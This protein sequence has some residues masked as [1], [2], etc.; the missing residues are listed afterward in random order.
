MFE[1]KRSR[2]SLCNA[3]VKL[4]SLLALSPSEQQ[5]EKTLYLSA[6]TC[7]QISNRLLLG[8]NYFYYKATFCL[9][10]FNRNITLNVSLDI[11]I[12]SN[13]LC[14]AWYVLVSAVQQPLK[15]HFKVIFLKWIIHELY[16][17]ISN[18]RARTHKHVHVSPHAR[19]LVCVWGGA[20]V[21]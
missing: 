15:T 5:S 2:S 13:D 8:Y 18:M 1:T 19:P 3:C 10:K 21:V 16:F 14:F 9:I 6:H 12:L 4:K 17:K 11:L 7:T 20:R